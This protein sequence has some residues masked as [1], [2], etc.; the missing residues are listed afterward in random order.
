[1]P[2]EVFWGLHFF[3]ETLFEAVPDLLDK[4]ERVL[5]HHYPGEQWV[6]PPFFQFGSWIGGDRDGNPFVTNDVT[7]S[8]LLENRLTCLR[9]YRRRIDELVR[10]LSI[11][12]RAVP[13][14]DRFRAA[15]ERELAGDRARG[16]DRRPQ[17][18][19][20]CSASTSACMLRRIQVM[21][22]RTERGDT[23]P[24]PAGLRLGRRAARRPQAAS[25]TS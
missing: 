10:A 19:A 15:L 1:M 8:T 18:R 11:T 12:E 20:R 13:I 3:N 6:V 16:G 17:S 9:R 22:E 25:R 23:R 21:I 14:S 4:V 5:A 2:Q 24:D 7:H